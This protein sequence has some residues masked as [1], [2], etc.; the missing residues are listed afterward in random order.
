MAKILLFDLETSP[1]IGYTWGK[2]E[3][4]VIEFIKETYL[5]CYSYKWLGDKNVVV[6][7]LPDYKGY[8]PSSDNDKQLVTSLWELFNEADIIIAHN[9]DCFDI[10]YANGRFLQHGLTPPTTYKTIDTLKTAR[11][12]FKMNSNK[13]DDLGR[14]LSLGQKLEH[15]GFAI[16]KGCMAGDPKSWSIMKRYNKQD[17][18]LLEQLYNELLPWIPNHPNLNVLHGET[19]KCAVCGHNKLWKIGQHFTGAQLHQR[20]RCKSCGANNYQPINKS[21]RPL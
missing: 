10:K 19:D 3:T 6:R 7:A 20:L 8:K 12:R 15:N 17:V 13:L 11:R 16:W 2:Y 9:G 4:N 1:N 14:K 21:I 18:V 5:L